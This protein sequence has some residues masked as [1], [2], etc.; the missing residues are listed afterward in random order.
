[1][2]I[3]P[4]FNHLFKNTFLLIFLAPVFLLIISLKLVAL[5]Y[6]ITYFGYIF[7]YH[8]LSPFLKLKNCNSLILI[9]NYP[10]TA[11]RTLFSPRIPIQRLTLSVFE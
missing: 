3:I 2:K 11:P 6:F 5:I 1:M 8:N 7:S 10:I 4:Q 9:P